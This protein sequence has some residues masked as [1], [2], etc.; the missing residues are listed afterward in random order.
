MHEY[1][2]TPIQF[3]MARELLNV[4][5]SAS[6]KTAQIELHNITALNVEATSSGG[7]AALFGYTAL[8]LATENG[9]LDIVQYLA[10]KCAWTC[11]A[12][13]VEK[14]WWSFGDGSEGTA[15]NG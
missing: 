6:H 11:W 7:Y 2:I 4:M 8:I 12:T 9:H 10:G 3:F 5:G 1:A 13:Q 15:G 14:H